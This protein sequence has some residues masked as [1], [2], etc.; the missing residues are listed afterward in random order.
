[1]KKTLKLR[2][3]TENTGTLFWRVL[4]DEKELLANNVFIKVPTH[5][6]CDTLSDG[7]IKY[8][9]SCDYSELVWEGKDLTVK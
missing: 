4:V 9:I 7:R 6:S 8:H 3:N 5:T 1:M 2:F